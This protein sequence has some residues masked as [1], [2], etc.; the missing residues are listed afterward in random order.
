MK[1]FKQFL[2]ENDPLNDLAVEMWL[3]KRFSLSHNHAIEL[4]R[5][6]EVEGHLILSNNL[7]DILVKAYRSEMPRD[8]RDGLH[9]LSPEDW[10]LR[11]IMDELYDDGIELE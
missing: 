8:V 6:L 9:Y 10:M 1:T 7:F 5:R 4:R 11:Q 3:R 2:S